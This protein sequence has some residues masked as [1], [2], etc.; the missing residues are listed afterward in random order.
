[1]RGVSLQFRLSSSN[2]RSRPSG[3]PLCTPS[4]QTTTPCAPP[5]GTAASSTIDAPQIEESPAVD[6]GGVAARADLKL[7]GPLTVPRADTAGT[8]YFATGRAMITSPGDSIVAPAVP[9]AS[10]RR[11]APPVASPLQ[12]SAR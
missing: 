6:T 5:A 2:R 1:M 3:F 10:A 4:S 12:A 7:T 9:L 8:L 11:G